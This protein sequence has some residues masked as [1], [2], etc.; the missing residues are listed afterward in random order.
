MRQLPVLAG[1]YGGSIVVTISCFC[2]Y[3]ADMSTQVRDLPMTHEQKV[4]PVRLSAL[5]NGDEDWE[6]HIIACSQNPDDPPILP[7]WNL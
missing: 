2:E 6:A 5:S 3:R 1:S 4:E 7:G